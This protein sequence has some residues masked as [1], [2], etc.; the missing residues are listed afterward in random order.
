MTMNI[1]QKKTHL[2]LREGDT[3]PSGGLR[4][5]SNDKELCILPMTRFSRH[6]T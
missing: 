5:N 3:E 2:M 1:K 4:D 6:Y